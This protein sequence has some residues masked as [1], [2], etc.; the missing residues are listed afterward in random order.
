LLLVALGA[1]AVRSSRGPGSGLQAELQ[2]WLETPL[3]LAAG[4]AVR[5]RA[6]L[7]EVFRR[8]HLHRRVAELEQRL[9]EVE[10]ERSRLAEAGRENQRLLALLGVRERVTGSLRG[11]RVI[12]AEPTGTVRSVVIDAGLADGVEADA[13][14]LVGEGLVGRVVRAGASTAVV[15]LLSDSSAGVAVLVERSRVQGVLVGSGRRGCR[16]KY[17]PTGEDVRAGDRLLSSGLDGIYAPGVPVGTIAAVGDGGDGFQEVEVEPA[18]ALDR[19]ET[20]LVWSRPGVSAPPREPEPRA[21]RQARL[22]R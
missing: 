18:A 11:A 13:A 10:L 15:Q 3:R 5:A 20:V 16:L 2:R 4:V 14:V 8:E 6:T 19:L 1:V 9:A 22:T 21:G 17:V 7:A 12:A